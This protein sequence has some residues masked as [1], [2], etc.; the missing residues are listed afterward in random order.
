MWVF[1][2][3]ILEFP[4]HFIPEKEP[5][6]LFGIF[7]GRVLVIRKEALSVYI[8]ILAMLSAFGGHLAGQIIFHS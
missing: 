4:W 1:D 6:V 2:L 8:K 5:K 7:F 3:S